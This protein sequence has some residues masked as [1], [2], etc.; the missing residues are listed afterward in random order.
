MAAALQQMEAFGYRPDQIMDA[1]GKMQYLNA[2]Q[3]TDPQTGL[4]F[5]PFVGITSPNAGTALT[6]EAQA[7]ISMRDS[8]EYIAQALSTAIQQGE[9]SANVARITQAGANSRNAANIAFRERTTGAGGTKPPNVPIVSPTVAKAIASAVTAQAQN[10]GLTLDPSAID[11]ATTEATR[12][13]QAPE[14][15]GY[16]N[17][18]GAVLSVVDELATGMMDGVESERLGETDLLSPSTWFNGEPRTVVKRSAATPAPA[19]PKPT[20]P[21]AAAKTAPP[22]AAV[23]FL[24]QNPNLAADFDRKYGQGASK[25]YLK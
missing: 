2:A 8:N 19:Q 20:T 21:T 1:I 11:F 13:Y 14:S 25:Q 16:K 17:V 22:A 5:A 18:Q 23:E 3:S 9:N 12:R 15:D 6:P 24:R 7:Q 4:P 10:L